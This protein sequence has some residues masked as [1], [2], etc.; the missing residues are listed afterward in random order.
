VSY[1]PPQN[2]RVP[3]R[4]ALATWFSPD[5]WVKTDLAIAVAAVVL[6]VS[7]FL[8]WFKA[9][10]EMNGG[11]TAGALIQPSGTVSGI[12][13]HHYLWVVLA[14]ALLQFAV[15]AVRYFPGRAV[16]LPG[17]GWILLVLSALSLLVVVAG[18]AVKPAAWFGGLQLGDGF[19]IVI[20]WDYGAE[21]ALG[22]AVVSLGIAVAA[23]RDR[24]R[25]SGAV[26]RS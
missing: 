17:Y 9:T 16:R 26:Y 12:S 22:A 8:P 1:W 11:S 13:I 19:S 18:S 24:S 25:T 21:V 6:A 4:S 5:R 23:I 15:L 2:R 3:L 20:G 7:V 14:L 10:V